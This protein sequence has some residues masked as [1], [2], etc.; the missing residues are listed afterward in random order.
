MIRIGWFLNLDAD[1][2]LAAGEGYTPTKAVLD[3]MAPHVQKLAASLVGP[4]E[5][6]V[7][8]DTTQHGGGAASVVVRGRLLGRAFCPTPR[9]LACMRGLG[10][11]PEPHPSFDVLRRVN[12]RAF[13]AELGQ[14]LPGA[15]FVRTLDEARGVVASPP[16]AG[17]QWRAKRAF[18]MAGRGQRPIAVG[19]LSDADAQFIAT[20]VA[21]DGGLQLEPEVTIVRELALHG[22]IDAEGALRSGRLVAQRCDDTGQWLE[23]VPLDEDVPA[24][25]EE[26]MRVAAALHA[27]GYFG[28]F[29]IDAFEYR[30]GDRVALNVRS[31]INARYSM[32]WAVG[33]GATRPDLDE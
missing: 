27:A 20:S 18:G 23:S 25:R 19:A 33:M 28:P 8:S 12:S 5:V 31:E 10:V 6:F 3:A 4:G 17:Q 22:L 11:E 2:E 32:G 9:A 13:S 30:D 29:G 15:V 7:A 21:R 16:P 26:A 1:L 24:L 14:T